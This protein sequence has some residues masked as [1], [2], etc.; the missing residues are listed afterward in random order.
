MDA[1][2][3]L[4]SGTP[5]LLCRIEARVGV[6]TLNRPAAKNALTLETKRALHRLIPELGANAEVGCVLLT[7]A[8]NAFCAGGDTKRMASEGRP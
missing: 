1:A 4:E 2:I 8:G 6:I 7:G 5:E 3:T